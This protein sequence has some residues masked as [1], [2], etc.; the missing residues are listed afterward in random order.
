MKLSIVIVNYNVKYYLEQCL[1]SVKKAID[2]IDAEVIVVDNHSKDGSL[3]YLE[4]LFPWVN[5]ISSN[6][7]L[8]FAKANNK[9]IEQSKG[10]YV[11]LLNPDTIV[12]EN[13]LRECLSFMDNHERAGGVGVRM[14][15]CDG[16]DAMES[17]RGIPTPMTA[18]YKMVG[19]CARYPR[20]KRF[21]KYYMGYL[22]WDKAAQIEVVS[23]AFFMTR[24]KTIDEVG[25]LDED[26]FM[27]GEDIDLSYRIL[28]GGWENWYL[29]LKILHYKGEST[30]KTNF[31]YVHVFYEA[32]FIF[33]RKHYGHLSIILG[34][35]IRVGILVKAFTT[36]MSVMFS[37]LRYSLGYV[38]AGKSVSS[39]YVFDVKEEHVEACERLGKKYGLDYSF[40]NRQDNEPETAQ[41]AKRNKAMYHVFD[42]AKYS[43]EEILNI[44]STRLVS[45]AMMAIYHPE[46]GLIIT[47]R[48]I[49]NE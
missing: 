8:G 42:T 2:G 35:P 1:R 38:K 40:L 30:Q 18:F 4:P 6:F 10:E 13:V 33:L 41:F 48:E 24:R 5:F 29:P 9:A 27:Y 31:R 15:K 14:L 34:L 25:M 37:R 16:T 36:L 39:K 49:L 45:R 46:R 22:P 44:S 7:N 23:G 47:E 3:K 19:L 26:F 21:G 17:R 32:M 12:G 43:F 20:S 11:L 28:K